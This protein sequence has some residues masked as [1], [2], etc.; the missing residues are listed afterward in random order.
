M[1]REYKWD[2]YAREAE[3]PPFVL[4][5]SEDEKIEVQNPTG[6]QIMRLGQGLRT[7]DMELMLIA[8]TGDAHTQVMGLLGKV[9][10]KALPKLIEDLMDHFGLYED[11]DLRGPLGGVV[12]ERRPDKIRAL[13]RSGYKPLGEEQP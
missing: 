1:T 9:G 13:L 6:V 2:D 11:V 12:T 8:L 10:H 7:G 4:R 3:V 5:V